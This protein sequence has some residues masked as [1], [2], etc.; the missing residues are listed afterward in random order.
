[1]ANTLKT[2][3]I[4]KGKCELPPVTVNKH[5]VKLQPNVDI[6][7][8]NNLKTPPATAEIRFFSIDE[9]GQEGDELSGFCKDG[10]GDVYK[11]ESGE[12]R[13]CDPNPYA[14]DFAYTIHGKDPDDDKKNLYDPLDPVI[15]IEPQLDAS[16][17]LTGGGGL[18]SQGIGGGCDPLSTVPL[19]MA[20]GG[21]LVG[22]VLP[23]ILKRG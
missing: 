6:R 8:V 19:L 21:F 7:F 2:V 18:E 1:M 20:A 3:Q 4:R 14:G 23:K 15:I 9:K 10:S 22:M 11:I 5:A 16:M 12:K 13:V 17:Y